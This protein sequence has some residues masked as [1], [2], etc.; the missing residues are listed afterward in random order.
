VPPLT[1]DLVVAADAAIDLQMHTTFSDGV[2]TPEQLID[3]LVLE[4]FALAAI[5]DH[6]YD[7][8]VAAA[9]LQRIAAQK[10]L[11]LLVA[12]EMSAA[13]RGMPTDMLCFGFDPA[14]AALRAVAQDITQRQSENTRQVWEYARVQGHV[15]LAESDLER[16]LTQPGAQ[17]PH[18]LLAALVG[19]MQGDASA[20][21]AAMTAAGFA[22]ETAD[23]AEVV[24]AV[25]QSGGV[26]LIAH[27]G[28]GGHYVRFDDHLLDEL[29][30]EVPI[31]GF[32]VYYPVHSPEQTAM[33]ERYAA[34]HRLLTSAGS[35]SHSAKK[36]PIKYQAVMA[37]SLLERLGVRVV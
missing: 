16:I 26:C 27:P 21:D 3:Y 18:A 29:R 17:Q 22:L 2:W 25:H 36:P 37:R 32:E 7:G 5:T 31:D 12:A 9:E 1:T 14:N 15:M 4:G 20:A 10:R 6:D 35:D 13:W 8:V 30:S 24:E 33:Y 19:A 23:I 34:T 11:P 28:R